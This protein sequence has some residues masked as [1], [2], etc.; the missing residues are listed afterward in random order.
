M[1]SSSDYSTMFYVL[2]FYVFLSC[3]TVSLYAVPI[4]CY[5]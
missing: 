4:L 1:W 5:A 2:C 3:M